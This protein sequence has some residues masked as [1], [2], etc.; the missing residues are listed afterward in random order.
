[1]F[2]NNMA[3]NNIADLDVVV[4]LLELEQICVGSCGPHKSTLSVAS[5]LSRNKQCLTYKFKVTPR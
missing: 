1:M 4:V 2:S 3:V 5:K